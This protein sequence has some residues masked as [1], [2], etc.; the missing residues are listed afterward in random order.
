MIRRAYGNDAMTRASVWSG[1][2]A[3]KEAEHH[4]KVTRGQGDLRRAKH[5]T[6][7]KQFGGLCLRIVGEP[8]RTLLQSLMCH[9]EQYRQ[10]S[11]VIEHAPRCCKVRAQ[12]SDARTERAPCYNLSRATSVCPGWPILHVEGHHWG[13]QLGLG[14]DP[15]TKQQSSQW[16][17]P[18]SPRLKKARQSRSATKCMLMVFF[19]IRG[20]VHHE[21]A[22]EGQNVNAQ[23]YCNVLRHLRE[24]VRRKWPELW[25]AGNWLLHDDDAP[26]HRALVTS[27]FLTHN[28]IITLLHPPYSPDLAPC[29]FFLFPKMKLQLKGRRFDKVEEIVVSFPEW[30]DGGGGGGSSMI[31]MIMPVMMISATR[32]CFISE[33]GVNVQVTAY[34]FSTHFGVSVNQV[35]SLHNFIRIVL[36]IDYSIQNVN[37]QCFYCF[38]FFVVHQA[39]LLFP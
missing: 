8:R 1:T 3:S 39:F 24:D 36:Y 14:Y 35:N 17:S 10:F 18:G 38:H 19:D 20:I 16:K 26:S 25:H 28:S 9:M 22:P 30:C 33:L 5:L 37:E 34:S 6:M 32:A 7:W 31:V 12:A 23:F 2:R 11:H 13:Q 29:D 15:E 21:F 27:E 4:S